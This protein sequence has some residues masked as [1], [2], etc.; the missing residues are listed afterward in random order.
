LAK[1]LR[2]ALD[3]LDAQI[4]ELQKTRAQLAALIDQPTAGPAVETAAPQKRRL[5]ASA[6]A[7]ISAAA[8]ARWARER[9]A[10]AKAQKPKKAARKAQSKTKPAKARPATAKAK[11]AP[12][13]KS[14][15][16]PHTP[17]AEMVETCPSPK[18]DLYVFSIAYLVILPISI[19]RIKI[20][21]QHEGVVNNGRLTVNSGCS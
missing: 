4:V 10:K 17:A 11:K 9:K 5:S 18:L 21:S 14:K 8:K 19:C 1:L 6:R 20:R 3:G 2:L 7:K 12:T 16:K 13:K 15:S